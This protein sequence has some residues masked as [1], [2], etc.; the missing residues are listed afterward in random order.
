MATRTAEKDYATRVAEAEA[1]ARALRGRLAARRAELANCKIV[2]CVPD[3]PKRAF[4]GGLRC[5]RVLSG[6]YGKVYAMHWAG[7]ESR[8]LS[9]SQDGKLL[10]WDTVTSQKL[11]RITLKSSWVMTCAF[12]R[13]QGRLIASG[14]LDN[15]CSVYA[16]DEPLPAVEDDPAAAFVVP[17]VEADEASGLTSNRPLKELAAHD[18][19][20]SCC[21]FVDQSAIVT[22]SGDSSLIFWDIEMSDPMRHF[23]DH[24]GDVMSFCVRPGDVNTI[25]SGACDSKAII[26]DARVAKAVSVFQAHESDVNSVEF[27][28]SGYAFG[29]GSDDASCKIFDMRCLAR[30]VQC[31]KNEHL[32][33]GVTS[34]AF[35]KSGRL[36]FAGY[37]NCSTYAWDMLSDGVEH[38]FAMSK[39]ADRVS[40]IGVNSTGQALGTGSWDTNLM[41]RRARRCRVDEGAR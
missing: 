14:G 15:V 4:G 32:L 30:E 19:Y 18:G 27:L 40:C 41:V 2:E 3:V 20:L 7:D 5:R 26:W 23:H 17:S 36:L 38:A 1:D 12:E 22:S 35:S 6:H 29:T 34:I 9:A 21:R 8:L 25:V 24:K 28:G 13:A 16:I 10:V 39:H 37:D 31:F 11:H 33:S